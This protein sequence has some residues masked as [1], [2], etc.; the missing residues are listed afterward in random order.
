MGSFGFRLPPRQA[1]TRTLQTCQASTI[2]AV[3]IRM[4]FGGP[5]YYTYDKEPPKEYNRYLF[6]I[7]GVLII[8]K[9]YW[10]PKPYSN[11]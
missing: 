5:L 6:T 2:G 10:S 1:G 9:V 7:L 11:Y 4:G 3:I 8:V